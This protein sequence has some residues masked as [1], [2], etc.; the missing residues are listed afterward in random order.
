MKQPKNRPPALA[1][2]LFRGVMQ[3]EEQATILGDM[4]EQY[5]TLRAERG[6]LAATGWYY[7]QIVLSLPVLIVHAIYWKSV[8][9]KNYLKTAVRSL[10]RQKLYS[11]INIVG[12][13]FG[14]ACCFL[15]SLYVYD[16][17]SYDKFFEDGERIYRVALERN[18]PDHTR[19][20]SSSSVMVA[21]TLLANYPDVEQATRLHRL[22]FVPQVVVTVGDQSFQEDKFLFADSNFF[23]VFSFRFL[24]GDPLTA[25]DAANKV[26]LTDKTARRYFGDEPA[27]N[28]TIQGGT[29]ELVV[30]AV[31]ED[32]PENSHIDLD[33]LG[34][35]R[36]I[37]YLD[38]AVNQGNWVSP[39][40]YTYIRLREGVDPEAF[41]AKLPDMVQTYG[42][43]QIKAQLGITSDDYTE[44]GH[45]YN[46]F[47]QPIRDI[48]LHSNME[49]ELQA[50]SNIAYVYLLTAIVGFILLISCINFVNL[51]TARST[52]R[53]KEVGVRKVMGSHRSHL[54]RQFLVESTV[55][56]SISLALAV[57]LAWLFLPT[58]NGLV[59][60]QLTLGLVEHPLVMAGLLGF[61]I[62]V[63][64]LAGGYP[65]LVISSMDPTTVLKGA[66]KTSR[67]GIW[68]RNSLVVFQFAISIV[69][70][71]GALIM[72]QQLD[73]IRTKQLGFDKE[74]VLVIKQAGRLATNVGAFKDE[75]RTLPDV[76]NVGGTNAA[77]GAFFGSSIYAPDDP[78]KPLFRTN[79]LT[80]D[81]DY[82]ET[83]DM[84]MTAGRSFS[85]EY[86]DSLSII[87]NEAAARALGWDDPIGHTLQPSINN[88]NSE[89]PPP[90]LEIVGI[91]KDFNF[92]SL[93]TEIGPLVIF[94]GVSAFVPSTLAV[95]L[96]PGDV[97]Q[98]I[99]AIE[100]KWRA[101]VPEQEMIFSFLDQDLDALYQSDQTWGQI[102]NA[103]T[104]LA[105]LLACVGLFGMAAY[106]TGQR[107]KEIG[108]RKVL[109]ASV[110]GII[111][112]LSTAFTRLIVI[113]FL[114]AAPVAY[115]AINRG[116]E[117]F[118][119]RVDV[120]LTT[121]ALAG[122]LTL[123][124]A[125]LTIS[126]QS[127][128]T[129]LTNPINSL[130]DE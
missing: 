126:Y 111:L 38:A 19:Y 55:I 60:K 74:N 108:I 48:H 24:E 45:G 33:L 81:D 94:N 66:F 80:I 7:G 118:A 63:G 53:A 121:L 43:A 61:A 12:L 77:P 13:A 90:T 73:Y 91:V 129:A 4:E 50:N 34:S 125:W 112:L 109:G 3:D 92:Q 28:Q 67:R 75:L 65:A 89:A 36:R 72:G 79:V 6:R 78:E 105:I 116:L 10:A 37:G 30:S 84:E 1:A 97:P 82:I 83:L 117:S 107:T 122:G 18:Y 127:I 8:M 104:L 103:F 68:L 86:N 26:V 51:A 5:H 9:F 57:V 46:Y 88:A 59:D 96:G 85:R 2:W 93:H 58:F 106:I 113:A 42:A 95:R 87:I 25:L 52:E 31:I 99:A 15:L 39:W 35:I 17:L 115:W 128:K 49:V 44:S 11:T 64:V 76:I 41:E 21:P 70:I 101:L 98:T 62:V 22:F 54:I 100:E 40:L 23:D 56:S 114:V 29:E 20:F 47:L 14:M 69:L 119:Y 123:L 102:I 120:G 110:A 130:R 32:L 27:L 16:E 71:S 124:L